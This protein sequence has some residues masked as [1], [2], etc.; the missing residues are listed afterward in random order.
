MINNDTVFWP[1]ANHLWVQR[2][3][4]K[5]LGIILCK[6]FLMWSLPNVSNKKKTG[7]ITAIMSNFG[8][9]NDWLVV[10]LPLWKIWVRPLGWWHSQVIWKVINV[11]FQ[12]APTRFQVL[13]F[14]AEILGPWMRPMSE[15]NLP[16]HSVLDLISRK[17]YKTQNMFWAGWHIFGNRL[18][19]T[20]QEIVV[21]HDWLFSC[22]WPKPISR[23]HCLNIISLLKMLVSS[24]DPQV[25]PILKS[26]IQFVDDL[27]APPFRKNFH[28]CV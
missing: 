6:T 25:S 2:S 22:T 19:F 21:D 4:G 24:D 7:L 26:I 13:Q 15:W 14:I 18:W 28:M 5:S 23:T 27:G 9:N 17:K 12:S 10:Y 3:R 16:R 11:M 8:L 1:L 20:I